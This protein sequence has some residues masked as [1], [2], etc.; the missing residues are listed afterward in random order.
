MWTVEYFWLW[1][2]L[3]MLM[4]IIIIVWKLSTGGGR[5]HVSECGLGTKRGWWHSE[6]LSACGRASCWCGT[7]W[8]WSEWRVPGSRSAWCIRRRWDGTRRS[9]RTAPQ[10]LPTCR[11]SSECHTSAAPRTTRG[12]VAPG[13]RHWAWS[14][15]MW[16]RW[17]RLSTCPASILGQSMSVDWC[18]A[19]LT[20]YQIIQMSHVRSVQ[21][22]RRL[23]IFGK[24]NILQ[25]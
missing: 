15:R 1:D 18:M 19:S 21:N 16:D 11:A 14:C 7:V 2:D 22:H 23:T 13:T 10:G 24:L 20:S 3:M 17:I 5:R 4:I 8:T 9:S 12:W 6:V 25:I